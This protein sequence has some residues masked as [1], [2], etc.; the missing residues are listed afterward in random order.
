MHKWDEVFMR[1]LIQVFICGVSQVYGAER[2]CIS[3]YEGKRMYDM[4]FTNYAG[5]S[6]SD[7][8]GSCPC[9]V[10][11]RNPPRGN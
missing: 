11:S 1:S 10:F 2:V 3:I 9:R 4:T 8:L 5:C 6:R 7:K